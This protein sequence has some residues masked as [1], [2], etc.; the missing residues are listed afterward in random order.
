MIATEA[1]LAAID[2]IIRCYLRGVKGSMDLFDISTLES[3]FIG[4]PVRVIKTPY[5]YESRLTGEVFEGFN[6]AADSTDQT[7]ESLN[8][9]ANVLRLWLPGIMGTMDYRTDRLNVYFAE[10]EDVDGMF[11][12]SRLSWG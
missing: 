10:Q 3:K 8:Q 9:H 7:V 6:Y 12:I 2:A 4:K 11:T 1:Q 5:R